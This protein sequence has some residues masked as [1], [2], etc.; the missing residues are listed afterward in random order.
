MEQVELMERMNTL[1]QKQLEILAAIDDRLK[2]QGG[3]WQQANQ[4]ANDYAAANDRVAEASTA[5]AEAG[6][7]A[8]TSMGSIS[9]SIKSFVG[10]KAYDRFT[11]GFKDGVSLLAV[12][13]ESLAQIVSNPVSAAFGFLGE[14]YDKIISKAAELAKESQQLTIAMER[15][16]EKFGSFNEG[17]DVDI[18]SR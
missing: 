6:N 8:A 1:L 11:N 2:G 12:N 16:R 5:A 17:I 3:T 14:L 10:D 4:A 7:K 13:F 15:V 18:G 9:D